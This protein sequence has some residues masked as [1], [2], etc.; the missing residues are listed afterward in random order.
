MIA[1]G[2]AAMSARP[3]RM[4]TPYYRPYP[5]PQPQQVTNVY[6]TQN[7]PTYSAAPPPPPPPETIYNPLPPP[8]APEPA[9]APVPTPQPAKEYDPVCAVPTAPVIPLPPQPQNE[10]KSSEGAKIERCLN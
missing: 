5:P 7:P 6:I 2:A 1:G 3:R 10:F 9:Y 4:H 8:P